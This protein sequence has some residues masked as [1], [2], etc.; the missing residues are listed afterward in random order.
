MVKLQMLKS[1]IF[2]FSSLEKMMQID[3]PDKVKVKE[4][5]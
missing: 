2:Y 5:S 4:K 1:N 3:A